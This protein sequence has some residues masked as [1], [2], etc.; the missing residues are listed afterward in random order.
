MPPRRAKQYLPFFERAGQVTGICEHVLSG[1][2][3]KVHIPKEGVTIA[4]APSG[5]RA[6]QRGQAAS[7]DGRPATLVNIPHMQ[8][9]FMC[10]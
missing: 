7:R 1:H 9:Q 2:R 4:F 10:L 6:P 8:M 5:V 3:V